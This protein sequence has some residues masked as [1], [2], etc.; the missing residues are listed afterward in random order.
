[1]TDTPSPATASSGAAHDPPP[2]LHGRHLLWLSIHTLFRVLTTLWFD[3]KVFGEKNVPERGGALL[4]CNHQSN[5]DPAMIQVRLRRP[6]SFLAKSELF[7]NPFFGWLIRRLYAFPIRQGKAD[8]GAVKESIRLLRDG[9]LLNIFPEGSRTPDGE[10]QP[11]QPGAA[12]VVKRAGVPVIP[13][14][15][16][17]SFHAW[18][19]HRPIFRFGKVRVLYGKPVRL[20]HLESRQIVAEIDR[21]F[22]AMLAEL[23]E[24]ER[25]LERP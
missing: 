2:D 1:M 13:T 3:L 9:H 18:P 5:L 10:L 11:I 20:D 15:I 25:S 7:T 17:G 24:K 21:L 22:H 8:V 6:M 16:D 23:R 19:R 4:L 12:L 14:V